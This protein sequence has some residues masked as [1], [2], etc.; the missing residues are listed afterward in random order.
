MT[1]L[2]PVY[3]DVRTL[4][5][6]KITP[7]RH[8]KEKNSTKAH[9]NLYKKIHL[10]GA[11]GCS[12]RNNGTAQTFLAF[13]GYDAI[14]V[15]PTDLGPNP[16]GWLH[17]IYRD[18]QQIL[19]IPTDDVVYHQMHLVSH[20]PIT[21][22]FWE[23]DE[24]EYPF[25]LTTV[26]YGVT[27][28]EPN[29]TTTPGYPSEPSDAVCG[30]PYGC[31]NY[32][33]MLRYRMDAYAADSSNDIKY[34]IYNSIT[35][36]DV[37]I[38]WRTKDLYDVLEMIAYIEYS[39]IARKTLTTLGFPIDGA[40][41]Q[42]KS[43]MMNTLISNIH[44]YITVSM[45]G[46]VRDIRRCIRVAKMFTEE[47]HKDPSKRSGVIIQK[48]E[49]TLDDLFRQAYD[50]DLARDKLCSMLRSAGWKENFVKLCG[51]DKS[52][53]DFIAECKQYRSYILRDLRCIF[54]E[55]RWSQSLGKNDFSVS[56]HIS[57]ANLANL[58]EAYRVHH[59]EL[60][61]ACWE[62]LTD[63]KTDSSSDT[64]G[65]Y[66]ESPVPANILCSLYANFQRL[67]QNDNKELHLTGF[68]WFNA[69]Q[70][71]LGT[72]H[73]ID[74]HPVLH[75]PSYLIYSSLNIVYAY[76]AGKVTDYESPKKR[77]LLLRRSE[78]QIVD[79]IRNLDQLTEQISRNDDAV[80]NNRSNTHTI[81]FS[82]PE[83]A[84]EFYHA[85]LRRIVAY[86]TEYDRRAD[87]VPDGF[88]YDFLLSPKTCSRFRFRHIF[89][90][91]HGDHDYY[92]NKIWPQKQAYVL[93]LPLESIFKPIDIFIPFV[94][95]CFHCFG[96]VL[97]QRPLRRQYMALFVSA[98]L[99]TAAGMGGSA[100]QN[101]F[102]GLAKLIYESTD[103]DASPYLSITWQQL[104]RKTYQVIETDA[105]DVLAA[106]MNGQ[107]SAMELS[108]WASSKDSLLAID[109]SISTFE[110]RVTIVDAILRHC[111]SYFTECYADA[112]TISLLQ[113]TPGEYLERSKE[114]LRRFHYAH[115]PWAD[116][117]EFDLRHSR[118]R[119]HLAQRFAVVLAA[120]SKHPH[121]RLADFSE[122]ACRKAIQQYSTGP[123]DI[124]SH[125]GYRHF[126]QT[127]MLNFNA[128]I[129][130]R[131]PMPSGS[132]LHPPAALQ[133]VIDYLTNSIDLLY[134]NPPV[135][136]VQSKLRSQYTLDD[137]VHDF[138]NIIR[139]GN[140]FGEEFYDFIYSHHK[141]IRDKAGV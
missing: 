127:L 52:R 30:S 17:D 48:I 72:H 129:D 59:I 12:K 111:H 135:L 58:L 11:S 78:E 65:W 126:S 8:D 71:L 91:E 115:S 79:F 137:L 43:C 42:I 118:Q 27:V 44:K 19:R 53:K 95:E 66:R 108:R 99:L 122:N 116:P 82:L 85:F 33:R 105:M 37:V 125:E 9:D 26:V 100:Y 21:Q 119:T 103:S 35:A 16:S 57:Y 55:Y 40:S 92:A 76:F 63:I 5:F 80:L 77:H 140:M 81:H 67:F 93:E 4:L 88:E 96:D 102:I 2:T 38:L 83:S 87:L 128:M 112:M 61:D 69:L 68:S 132:S 113:L 138:K 106:Q 47:Q 75:G 90:T 86:I 121:P 1:N 49:Q 10:A 101:L 51:S 84:L 31:S 89:R 45:H 15:Y 32:E 94:H 22:A 41:G 117:H 56:A 60:G 13:G 6:G 133:Y 28:A 62:F 23:T 124:D 54:P 3:R 110:D 34:A 134:D 109:K 74:H 114:E 97:R 130:H 7:V 64:K 24:A 141:E 39:G 73:Y 107:V 139:N 29:Q 36:G 46:S 25:F 123:D 14:C 131:I 70:E 120:C 98:N 18:K 104:A 50:D 20:H 136:P